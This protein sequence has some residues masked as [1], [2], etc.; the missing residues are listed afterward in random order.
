MKTFYRLLAAIAVI[1][2]LA[3]GGLQASRGRANREPLPTTVAGFTAVDAGGRATPLTTEGDGVLLVVSSECPHC[4][5]LLDQWAAQGALPKLRL[6][7]LECAEPGQQLSDSLG[8]QPAGVLGPQST[9]QEA[10]RQLG[11][12]GTPTLLHLSGDRILDRMVGVPDSAEA[13]RWLALSR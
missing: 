4:H 9:A 3:L 8:F 5:A 13:A 7:V 10:A 2:V 11:I 6:L 1:G 12:R